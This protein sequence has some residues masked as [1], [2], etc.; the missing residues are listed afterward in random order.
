MTTNFARTSTLHDRCL[1]TPLSAISFFATFT[2]G[3]WRVHKGA[4]EKLQDN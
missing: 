1:E 3:A 4:K 2:L